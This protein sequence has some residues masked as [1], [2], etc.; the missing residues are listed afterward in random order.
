MTCS[1]CDKT[2]LPHTCVEHFDDI[3]DTLLYFCDDECE[4]EYYKRMWGGV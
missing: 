4:T 3:L 2:V 1:N